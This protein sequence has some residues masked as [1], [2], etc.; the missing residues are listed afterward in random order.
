MNV[1]E[2]EQ[3]RHHIKANTEPAA[4]VAYRDDTALV[5]IQLGFGV[6]M[7]AYKM[8]ADRHS[9]AEPKGYHYLHE[10]GDVL[11]K[12]WNLRYW[13]IGTLDGYTWILLNR[14]FIVQI[15]LA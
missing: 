1:E 4:R 12:I 2:N 6:A 14:N 8:G 5:G 13:H 15:V 3:H 7:A 10:Q 11:P 9:Q